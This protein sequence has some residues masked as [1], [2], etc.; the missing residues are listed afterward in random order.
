MVP[1]LVMKF[2]FLAIMAEKLSL[3]LLGLKDPTITKE[4]QKPNEDGSSQCFPLNHAN[5]LIQFAIGFQ[6]LLH[7]ICV[8]DGEDYF[9]QCITDFPQKQHVAAKRTVNCAREVMFQEGLPK[10]G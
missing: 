8:R 9:N 6:V 1:V 7:H 4:W 2:F 10:F 3:I 5:A